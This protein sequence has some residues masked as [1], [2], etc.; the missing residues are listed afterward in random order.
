M[1]FN[2]NVEDLELYKEVERARR[3]RMMKFLP[4]ATNYIFER[5][6]LFTREDKIKYLDFI[7][8][9]LMSEILKLADRFNA[10]K[11]TIKRTTWGS[12]KTVSLNAWVNRNI[13]GTH[14]KLNDY[15]EHLTLQGL[16]SHRPLTDLNRKFAYDTYDDLVDEEFHRRLWDL[17]KQEEH[18]FN[19][20]DEYTVL[21]NKLSESD[22]MPMLGIHYWHGTSGIG[23]CNADGE[24]DTK[25][26][27]TLKELKF[28]DQACTDMQMVIDA[29][30]EKV[31]KEFEQLTSDDA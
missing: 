28:L 5:E 27:F 30:A 22:I 29:F 6:A 10:E 2:W 18:W 19:T 4:T 13:K 26:K 1:K 21:A 15:G 9:G 23:K 20:H 24:I 16:K 14:I 25:L 31:Q 8:D 7:M 11:D 17:E 3:M 12:F